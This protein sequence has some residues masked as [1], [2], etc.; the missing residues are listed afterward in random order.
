MLASVR[1][2]CTT[3]SFVLWT[4]KGS[5]L[6]EGGKFEMVGVGDEPTSPVTRTPLPAAPV[7][8]EFP[9]TP[10]CCEAPSGGATWAHVEEGTL[11]NATNP[12]HDARRKKLRFT[13]DLLPISRIVRRLYLDRNG[14]TVHFCTPVI[15]S[16]R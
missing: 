9:R 4:I 3:P 15:P 10:N 12:R 6:L 7:T 16:M 5:A 13:V 1:A 2:C 14:G 11:R 8:A